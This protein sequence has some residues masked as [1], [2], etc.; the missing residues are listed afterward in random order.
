MDVAQI[1]HLLYRRM[2]FGE[3]AN[4]RKRPEISGRHRS[5]KA[6][7]NAEGGALNDRSV[8]FTFPVCGCRV[9]KSCQVQDRVLLSEKGVQRINPLVRVWA[10]MRPSAVKIDERAKRA[11]FF[12][13]AS[14]ESDG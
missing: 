6:V 7:Q 14:D 11:K 13:R 4:F 9:A 3:T 8:Q 12:P 10:G 2:A 1:F 5:C